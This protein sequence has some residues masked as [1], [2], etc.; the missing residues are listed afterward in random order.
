MT[1]LNKALAGVTKLGFDTAPVIYFIEAHASY[2][3]LVTEIF[4]QVSTGMLE[5]FTSVITLT[6]TLIHPIRRGEAALQS[7]YSE[8][9]V[10]SANFQTLPIDITCAMSAADLRAGITS[11]RQMRCS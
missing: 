7:Q 2:D 8:L 9:L 1:K 10:N 3:A 4:Q 11:A 6:E 5:G